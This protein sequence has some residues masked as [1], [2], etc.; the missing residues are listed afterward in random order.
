MTGRGE[1]LQVVEETSG[2]SRLTA[3]RFVAD[4]FGSSIGMDSLRMIEDINRDERSVLSVRNGGEMAIP[5]LTSLEGVDLNLEGLG[6]L[7]TGAI[8]E[9]T[10]G[11]I[12]M[13]RLSADFST[14]TNASGTV[15]EVEGVA[16]TLTNLEMI[17]GASFF[18]RLG[19][20]LTLPMATSYFSSTTTNGQVNSFEAEGA[21][22]TLSLPNLNGIRNGDNYSADIHIEAGEHDDPADRN[23]EPRRSSA[24][25]L[26]HALRESSPQWL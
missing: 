18:V 8:S 4:G 14:L 7:T 20:S 13:N 11:R 12:L 26:R 1:W 15:F 5:A 19:G 6:T 24:R 25:G 16:V 21:G 9:F 22:S 17:D 3:V 10:Q 2:D 23:V